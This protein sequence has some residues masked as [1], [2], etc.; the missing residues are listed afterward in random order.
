MCSYCQPYCSPSTSGSPLASRQSQSTWIPTCK[1]LH[2]ST[3]SGTD[4]FLNVSLSIVPLSLSRS[5]YSPRMVRLLPGRE[6]WLAPDVLS[7]GASSNSVWWCSQLCC[8]KG[9]IFSDV[10]EFVPPAV[11]LPGASRAPQGSCWR[12][13]VERS[14]PLWK[15]GLAGAEG[16]QSARR[17][18][19]VGSPD[20]QRWTGLLDLTF[21]RIQ[22]CCS[23]R[24]LDCRRCLSQTYILL[25][26]VS[27][28]ICTSDP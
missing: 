3:S 28:H 24:S 22:E 27:T 10:D 26:T 1:A 25:L 21:L 16:R 15:T 19:L 11:A 12:D 23:A 7:S 9:R 18:Y 6:S 8:W 4:L 20:S 2:C 13:S 5:Q 14:R 17:D